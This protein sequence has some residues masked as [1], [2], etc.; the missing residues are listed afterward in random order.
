MMTATCMSP[1]GAA[2]SSFDMMTS[3]KS[4]ADSTAITGTAAEQ[5]GV[6]LQA[7]TSLWMLT[8]VASGTLPRAAGA[9]ESSVASRAT[10]QFSQSIGSGRR[11][12]LA[13]CDGWQSS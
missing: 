8:E 6:S 1:S 2:V 10:S 11:R 5:A 3:A 4:S 7:A 13:R 12:R 9:E